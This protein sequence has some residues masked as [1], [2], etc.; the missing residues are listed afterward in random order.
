MVENVIE[1][2]AELSRYPLTHLKIFVQPKIRSPSSGSPQ[3]ILPGDSRIC[4][5]IGSHCWRQECIRVEDCISHVLFVVP[6]YQR[7]VPDE[8][9]KVSKSADRIHRDISWACGA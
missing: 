8:I 7:S 2:G 9:V 3:E 4:K 6:N 5:N 1:V